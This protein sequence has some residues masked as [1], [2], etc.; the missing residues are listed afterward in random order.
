MNALNEIAPNVKMEKFMIITLKS[1]ACAFK[2][3]I[4]YFNQL[5]WV[6]IL[7]SNNILI[8]YPNNLTLKFLIASDEEERS[9]CLALCFLSFPSW[10]GL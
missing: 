8:L 1:H 3:L 4:L 10:S 6:N 5:T 7:P 9:V 2:M